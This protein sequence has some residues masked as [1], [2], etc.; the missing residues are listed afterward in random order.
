MPALILNNFSTFSLQIYMSICWVRKVFLYLGAGPESGVTQH[1]TDIKTITLCPD[2]FRNS[3]NSVS[4]GSKAPKGQRVTTVLLTRCAVT[5]N[6]EQQEALR[7][8]QSLDEWTYHIH[9]TTECGLLYRRRTSMRC[10]GPGNMSKGCCI[11]TNHTH[12]SPNSN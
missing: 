7:A 3:R 11:R 9:W 8:A 5:F 1:Q 12:T 10:C 6:L 4:L 2:A